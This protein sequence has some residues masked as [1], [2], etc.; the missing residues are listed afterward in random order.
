MPWAVAAALLAVPA[1]LAS[2][3]G[4][5]GGGGSGPAIDAATGGDGTAAADSAAKTDASS[6][7]GGEDGASTPDGAGADAGGDA[8]AEVS[9]D[10]PTVS[11]TASAA[12]AD[13]AQPLDSATLDQ[14]ADGAADIADAVVA[15]DLAAGTDAAAEVKDTDTAVTEIVDA[16]DVADSAD[17]KD[18]TDS[19]DVAFDVAA[20]VANT[21]GPGNDIKGLLACSDGPIDYTLKGVT[22]TYVGP[23]Q[24]AVYDGSVT[25]GMLFY[26][27]L[28]WPF[29]KPKVGDLVQVHC[30]QYGQFQGQQEV[31]A[32]DSLATVGVGDPAATAIDLTSAAKAQLGETSESRLLAGTGLVVKSMAGNDGVLALPVAGDTVLRVDGTNTLCPGAIVDLKA[33][34]LT[35]YGSNHRVHLMNGAADLG[36]V[37]TSKCAAPQTYDQSN[38]G[39]EEVDDSDPPPDF[40]KVGAALKAVRTTAQFKTG[41]AGAALTWT[42]TENQDLMAGYFVPVAA[43]QKVSAALWMLDNDPAGRGRVSLTFYKADKTTAISSQFSTAYSADSPTWVQ[44]AFAYT[45]PAEAAFVRVFVRLYD[46][47]AWAG[48]ATVYVD[49]WSVVVQ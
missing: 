37:D 14:T 17:T 4:G 6:N 29:P 40:L 33:A 35:Q 12:D 23:K 36:T 20:D 38:W 19:N 30:T 44:L 34:L 8:V 49:D 24:F 47:T 22:V 18:S 31:L 27:D 5:G 46:H 7:S 3:G 26:F 48:T 13:A 9:A 11:D 41:K 15:P 10:V 43:G 1:C 2:G 39:F 32:A 45:A 25:R 28:Q 16:K 21:C 42:S